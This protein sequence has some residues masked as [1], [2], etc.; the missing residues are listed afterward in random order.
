ML[1]NAFNKGLTEGRNFSGILLDLSALWEQQKVLTYHATLHPFR[2]THQPYRLTDITQPLRQAYLE[3]TQVKLNIKGHVKP[4]KGKEHAADNAILSTLTYQL[5][6]QGDADLKTR[7]SHASGQLSIAKAGTLSWQTTSILGKPRPIGMHFENLTSPHAHAMQQE[8]PKIAHVQIT[9]QNQTLVQH[10][11]QAAAKQMGQPTQQIKAMA[12]GFLDN[13]I[14]QSRVPTIK[15]VLQA[16]KTFLQKPGNLTLALQ[17]KT[18]FDVS[19]ISLYS[20]NQ[21]T[22]RKH[23]EKAL[24]AAKSPAEK[25]ALKAHYEQRQHSIIEPLLQRIGLTVHVNQVQ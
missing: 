23:Y 12:M 19:H 8:I 22:R 24:Q 1:K 16:V 21:M 20:H 11:W 15:T 7:K 18:P 10:L 13:S 17:P 2:L 4:G 25:I 6:M 3:N 5:H 14:Q 9:Y